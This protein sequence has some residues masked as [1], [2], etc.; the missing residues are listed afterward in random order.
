MFSLRAFWKCLRNSPRSG[1]RLNPELIS[2]GS[3]QLHGVHPLLPSLLTNWS[4]LSRPPNPSFCATQVSRFKR[5]FAHFDLAIELLAGNQTE[6][7]PKPGTGA[8]GY[9]PSP[10]LAL[11]VLENRYGCE[12]CSCARIVPEDVDC[13]DLSDSGDFRI[14]NLRVCSS[15]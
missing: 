5:I 12:C 6:S 1:T 11:Q 13:G 3:L 14:N 7:P 9:R 10:L 2:N 8:T 4:S 15:R